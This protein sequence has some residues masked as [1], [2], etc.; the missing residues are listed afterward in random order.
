MEI[1]LAILKLNQYF[2]TKLVI[3]S[4]S[5]ELLF[6]MI[7]VNLFEYYLNNIFNRLKRHLFIWQ[8]IKTLSRKKKKF[9]LFRDK[10]T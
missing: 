9:L 4:F 8:Y 7:F 10:K 6:H 3:L 2:R 5:R 1:K